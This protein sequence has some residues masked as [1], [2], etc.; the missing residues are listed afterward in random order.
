MQCCDTVTVTVTTARVPA[1]ACSLLPVAVTVG[2]MYVHSHKWSL[3]PPLP[4]VCLLGVLAAPHP[5]VAQGH[6]QAVP[7]VPVGAPSRCPGHASRASGG[8][9][10]SV[11][12]GGGSSSFERPRQRVHCTCQWHTV[13][14]YMCTVHEGQH[15]GILL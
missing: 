2:T 15:E 9:P 10:G 5:L 11:I 3:K 8:P 13:P 12:L 14:I 4:L 1:A 6:P 7:V